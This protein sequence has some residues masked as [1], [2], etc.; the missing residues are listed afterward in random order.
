LILA[1]VRIHQWGK[2]PFVVG[3]DSRRTTTSAWAVA[4]RVGETRPKLR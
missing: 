2:I 3:S 1:S 4:G